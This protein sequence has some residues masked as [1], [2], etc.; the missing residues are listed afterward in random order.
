MTR[1][2]RL[3]DTIPNRVV[4]GKFSY[5]V[6]VLFLILLADSIISYIFPIV[7]GNHMSSNFEIGLILSLSSVIGIAFDFLIPI[8]F[9]RYGWKFQLIVGIVLALT[10]PIFT[11]LGDTYSIILMFLLGVIFWGIYYEFIMFAQQSFMVEEEKVQKYPHDWS[12]IELLTDVV[13]II[14][15]IIGAFLLIRGIRTYTSITV[16]IEILA[17]IFAILL[18][19]FKKNVPSHKPISNIK[20]SVSVLKSIRSWKIISKKVYVVLA[21]A[22]IVEIISAAFV[23]FA[24]LYGEQLIHNPDWNWTLMV[25]TTAPYMIGSF[26]MMRLSLQHGKK[27]LSQIAILISGLI[28]SLLFFFTSKLIPIAIIIFVSNLIISICWPLDDA[29]FS[30]LQK[31]LGKHGIDLIGLSQASYSIAYIIAPSLMGFLADK[32]GY[33]N[34]FALMG[35]LSIISGII[36]L[37]I[38]PRKIRLPQKALQEIA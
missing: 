9:P 17:L 3:I 8:V 12:I 29:I 11:A 35:V 37:I 31:R 4:K 14:G 23:S 28:L 5:F 18:V 21:M 13:E 19:I 25:L 30:D 2:K 15:P 38:T 32:V 7:L 6:V 33:N 27:R 20:N 1:G 16:L 10:F 24:G 22:A 36:F 34:A 26:V